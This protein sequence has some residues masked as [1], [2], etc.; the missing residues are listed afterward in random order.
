M[1][2]PEKMNRSKQRILN[3]RERRANSLF[4]LCLLGEATRYETLAARAALCAVLGDPAKRQANE[5]I[6]KD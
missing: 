4:A 3:R 2:R 5:Q 1:V 6:A